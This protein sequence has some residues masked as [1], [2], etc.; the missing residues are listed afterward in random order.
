MVVVVV[1]VRVY[2]YSLGKETNF[3]VKDD[4]ELWIIRCSAQQKGQ[5]PQEGRKQWYTRA[6]S[7]GMPVR[8]SLHSVASCGDLSSSTVRVFTP[9]KL[10]RLLIKVPPTPSLPPL[11][12]ANSHV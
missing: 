4:L 2:V 5:G 11:L 3:Q 6:G 12:P 9:W 8:L 7:R 10:Q 1:V